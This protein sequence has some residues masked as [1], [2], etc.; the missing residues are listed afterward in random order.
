MLRIFNPL[1]L[2]PV[3]ALVGICAYAG[4]DTNAIFVPKFTTATEMANTQ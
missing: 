2:I 3:L 1:I 4:G